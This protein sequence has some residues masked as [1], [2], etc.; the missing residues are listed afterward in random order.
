MLG[1]LGLYEFESMENIPEELHP[2]KSK[3]NTLLIPKS[4]LNINKK[5]LECTLK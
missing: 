1:G 4:K 2:Y 3:S 5:T